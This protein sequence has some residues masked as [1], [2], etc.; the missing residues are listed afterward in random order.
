MTK[1]SLEIFSTN[2]EESWMRTQGLR[3]CSAGDV[4]TRWLTHLRD[5]HATTS[6]PRVGRLLPIGYAM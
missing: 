1:Q 4:G 2:A 3:L 6:H 5:M